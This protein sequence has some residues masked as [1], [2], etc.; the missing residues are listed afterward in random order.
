MQKNNLFLLIST[1]LLIFCT[2]QN[3]FAQKN[4]NKKEGK[5]PVN[6][7]KNVTRA[8]SSDRIV[9]DLTHDNWIG[10][11]DSVKT[12]WYSRGFAANLFF[13]KRLGQSPISVA[14]GAGVSCQ[15]VFHN[16]FISTDS[17][18]TELKTVFN[19]IPESINYKKNKLATT[20]LDVPFE[21]RLHTNPKSP[22]RSFK[23]AIGA[24]VGL[25]INE[26]TKY[27]GDNVFG[28]YGITGANPPE[29]KIKTY[30]TPN[31]N[32]FRYGVTARIGYGN[33]NLF[34]FYSLSP[35]FQADKAVTTINPFSVGISF[36]SF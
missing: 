33:I 26:H 28:T 19:P 24:K 9:F 30:N 13:D 2:Q 36:N 10:A 32:K 29:V 20:Y 22:S 12:N 25:L 5:S 8:K 17:V 15:N 14:I 27:K 31:I 3:T 7:V 18:G 16:S 4:E 6:K 11:P 35:L 34:G 21:L 1:F 23:L